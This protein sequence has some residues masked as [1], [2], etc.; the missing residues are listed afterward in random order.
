MRKNLLLCLAAC[1]LSLPTGAQ[2]FSHLVLGGGAGT[3]GVSLELAAPLGRYVVIRAGY[4]IAPGLLGVRLPDI[5]V[6]EHP[7][8]TAGGQAGVPLTIRLGNSDARLLFNIHP[9][10]GSGFHLTAGAYLGSA[11]FLRGTLEGMPQDYDTVGLDV[12]GYLVKARSGI[13]EA[14]L[15]AWGV[16]SSSFAVKPYVGVG[17]GRA[18]REDR[19]LGW[20]ADLGVQYQ[21][22][23]S[24]WADGEGL[25]GRIKRVPLSGDQLEALGSLDPYL[26]YTRFW[27]TLHFH[28]YVS[29]F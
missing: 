29:L 12:D 21:G 8:N 17:Y 24:L 14:A 13:L 16:G 25:T 7:G 1:L 28:V 10:P 2:A 5:S 3:D 15:C 4:G 6:P 9:F 26:S 22:K 20:S 27:P 18:V 23:A 19:R 11:R